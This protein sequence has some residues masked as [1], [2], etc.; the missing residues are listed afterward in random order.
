M[1]EIVIEPVTRVE[2]HGKVTIHLDDNGDVEEARF[3]VTEFRGFE[4]FLEGRKIWETPRI[5]TRICGICPVSHHLAAAKACDDLFGLEIPPAAAMLRELMHVGQ[6]VHS[7]S[8]HFFYLAA[9]D[10][11]LPNDPA[12]RN[13]MGIIGASPELAKKAI[14]LRKF[15]QTVI[16]RIGG[17][18]IHPVTAIPGGMSMSLSP[19]VRDEMLREVDEAIEL[20]QLAVEVAKDALDGFDPDFARIE[21]NHLGLVK[22]GNL[23]LYDGDIRLKG[24]DGGIL[25]E[26]ECHNY[27]DYLGEHVNS[28]SYLKFPF[29]KK[30]GYPD[31]VYRVGPLGRLNVADSVSTPLAAEEFEKFKK[32]G[33]PVQQTLYYH[34][35][36]MIETLYAS[37]RAKELLEDDEIISE[38]V[39]VPVVK[40]E[41]EGVGVIEAPRGTLLHHYKAD[42]MGDIT[43]ANLIVA[44]VNNNP[45]MDMS[46]KE[47][48]KREIKGGEITESILNHI[49]MA[50]R[51]YDPCIS[52]ATHAIGKMPLVVELYDERG[53][54]ISSVAR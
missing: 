17:K 24:M 49:E 42:D 16:E 18:A 53:N 48:A 4:K 51:C 7:H 22:D 37:E 33:D 41:G 45:A 14:K 44:T 8:L 10:F 1:K 47:V 13:I 27:L 38:D 25:E 2:G 15:G 30:Q 11:L 54:R 9:P 26:F 12:T 34:Y 50:I 29:Y 3:H 21:T 36:R 20:S 32:M 28:W 35:A 23:E 39:R 43:S 46:V 52:C 5:T 19:A 6:T 40:G 31:G